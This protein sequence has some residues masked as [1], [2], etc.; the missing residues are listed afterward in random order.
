[1]K[2]V[3]DYDRP[4]QVPVD[5]PRRHISR[6]ITAPLLKNFFLSLYWIPYMDDELLNLINK[7][8]AASTE[9]VPYYVI[10]GR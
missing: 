3:P 9:T 2:L 1:M 8:T 6:N 10:L 5:P 7:W 4:W